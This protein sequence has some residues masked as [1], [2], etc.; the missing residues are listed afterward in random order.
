MT[1]NLKP[2]S[3]NRNKKKN[4]VHKTTLKLEG[5]SVI[6]AIIDSSP[7]NTRAGPGKEF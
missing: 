6:A 5:F 2:E 3:K 7:S 4:K 1:E